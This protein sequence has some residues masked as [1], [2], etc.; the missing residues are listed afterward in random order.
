MKDIHDDRQGLY[1]ATRFHLY[2]K[3][4][5]QDVAFGVRDSSVESLGLSVEGR[6]TVGMQF[7]VYIFRGEVPV[8]SNLRVQVVHYEKGYARCSY[9]DLTRGQA[10]SLQRIVT[11]R[12]VA[13]APIQRRRMYS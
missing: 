2:A 5:N 7:S 9:V 13:G 8:A 11:R 1:R 4:A 3:V 12:L 10:Q 6:L